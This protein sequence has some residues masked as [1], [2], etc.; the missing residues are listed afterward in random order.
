M[1]TKVIVESQLARPGVPAGRIDDLEQRLVPRADNH[2]RAETVGRG[3]LWVPN[4]VMATDLVSCVAREA[5]S[6]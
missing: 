3:R 2:C 4:L 5:G 1:T 6:A